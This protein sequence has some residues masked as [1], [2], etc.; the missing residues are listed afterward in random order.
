MGYPEKMRAPRR[1]SF[2]DIPCCSIWEYKNRGFPYMVSPDFCS[3]L[4]SI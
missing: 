3:S 2:E 4:R 1:I